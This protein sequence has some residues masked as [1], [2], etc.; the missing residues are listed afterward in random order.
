MKRMLS[1]L[2][3]VSILLGVLALPAQGAEPGVTVTETTVTIARE[4]Y[5][6]QIEK[7][8]SIKPC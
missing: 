8:G 6:I 1:I 5:T 7:A 4:N 2:L 3:T